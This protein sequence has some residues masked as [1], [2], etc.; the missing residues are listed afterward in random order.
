MNYFKYENF[1]SQQELVQIN[2]EFD[3]LYKQSLFKKAGIGKDSQINNQIRSDEILWWDFN[4]LTQTQQII[5]TKLENLK[6]KINQEL[7]LG[8]W[9]FEGHYAV[10]QKGSF[11]KK[12]IDTF[13][14]DDK[15][16][17]SFVLYLNENWQPQ[18]GGELQIYQ[19]N[20]IVKIDPVGGTLVCFLS[21]EVEHEVLTANNTRK[22]F[23]GW[24]K[25]RGI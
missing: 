4:N 18:D 15:R 8:L 7:F 16:T 9:D 17:L 3:E 11:Y 6:V 21:R 20:K 24:F 1:I 12:H 22:T 14:N 10:Y 23:T 25:V 13:K 19:E 2:Q 5:G